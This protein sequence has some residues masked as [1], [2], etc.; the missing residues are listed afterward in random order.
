[1][2]VDR[3]GVLS[4]VVAV[5]EATDGEGGRHAS[6]LARGLTVD[7]AVHYLASNIIEILQR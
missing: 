4:P 6:L 5:D 7:I 3:R 2:R 1:M